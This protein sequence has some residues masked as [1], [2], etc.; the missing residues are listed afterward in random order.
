M[1]EI[2][3]EQII[4]IVNEPVINFELLKKKYRKNASEIL[5]YL[6]FLSQFR[7]YEHTYNILD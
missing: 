5:P 4:G 3:A 6:Q 2:F 1:N 7:Y